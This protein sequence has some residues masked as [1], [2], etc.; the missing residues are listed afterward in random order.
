MAGGDQ[1]LVGLIGRLDRRLGPG[2]HDRV[3]VGPRASQL[4]LAQAVVGRRLGQRPAPPPS[5]PRGVSASGPACCSSLPHRP[6]AAATT[7]VGLQRPRS[8]VEAELV[9]EQDEVG[10]AAAAHAA[11]ARRPRA[12]RV[13]SSRARRPGARSRARTLNRSAPA[14]AAL[15]VGTRSPGTCESSGRRAPGQ[16]FFRTWAPLSGH[17]T[18]VPGRRPRHQRL[19]LLK[20]DPRGTF[21]RS[22]HAVGRGQRNS[23]MTSSAKR[24]RV[25][26]S[27]RSCTKNTN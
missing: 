22:R 23:P 24:A 19:C 20:L 27:P 18:N 6:S 13:R 3:A 14:R 26:R 16:N 9:G 12:P 21:R 17:R 4:D 5:R 15:S 7:L 10:D 11:A 25:S 2:E 1:E 8:G